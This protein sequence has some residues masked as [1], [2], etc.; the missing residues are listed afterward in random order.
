M[1]E[2]Y[3][4]ITKVIESGKEAALVTIISASS[5]TPR[6]IGAKM[7]VMPD[8]SIIGT[9]GGGAIELEAIRLAKDAIKGRKPE[10]KHFD[11]IPDQEPGMVCGG[12]ME[13]MIEPVLQIPSLY[14]FGAGHIA[15]TL[16]KIAKLMGF[17]VF[18][19]DDRAEFATKERFPDA[20]R[21]ITGDF[22]ESFDKLHIDKQ[23]YIVIVTHGHKDDQRV[24]EQALR[25][26]APY[27][28]MIGSRSKVKT[29]FDNLKAKEFEEDRIKS[30]HTPIGLEIYA[31][32]PEEISISIMAEIIKIRR[33]P[34]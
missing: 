31:E 23:S 21:I 13:I 29:V 3:K 25:T 10:R 32:T 33:S 28:G 1:L 12:E 11:L 20:D 27:I 15:L 4:E 34:R 8:G 18:V 6:H 9:I 16:V 2:V 24:L 30:V 19:I 26:H 17:S 7:L 5:S 14:I 22:V